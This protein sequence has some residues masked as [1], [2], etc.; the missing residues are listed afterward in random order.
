MDD[1]EYFYA[2]VIGLEFK[3][4]ITPPVDFSASLTVLISSSFYLFVSLFYAHNC[5]QRFLG[6]YGF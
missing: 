2:C 4:D 1:V 5:F 6:F 3:M